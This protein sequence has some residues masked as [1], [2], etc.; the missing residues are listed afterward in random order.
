MKKL[1]TILSLL[2]ILGLSS[3]QVYAAGAG[4]NV[5]GNNGGNTGVTFGGPNADR[6]GWIYYLVDKETRQQVSET[7]GYVIQLE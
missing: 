3:I 2:I 6:T 1:F 7:A 4:G 5:G